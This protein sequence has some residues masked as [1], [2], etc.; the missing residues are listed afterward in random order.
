VI[1]MDEHLWHASLGGRVRRQW[2]VDYFADPAADPASEAAVREAK[3]YLADTYPPDWDGGYDSDRYPTYGPYWLA[4][5]RPAVARLRQL[6]AV[7]LSHAEEAGAR[8]A[9]AARNN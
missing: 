7:D 8:A 9:R 6:G 2:R 3:A 5:G 1:V 4:S